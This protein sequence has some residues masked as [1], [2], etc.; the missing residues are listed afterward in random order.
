MTDGGRSLE[1]VEPVSCPVV[2]AVPPPGATAMPFCTGCGTPL[3]EGQQFCTSCGAPGQPPIPIVPVLMGGAGLDQPPAAGWE[4]VPPPADGGPPVAAAVAAGSAASMEACQAVSLA[5]QRWQFLQ[6][7]EAGSGGSSTVL[8]PT[9]AELPRPQP[10]PEPEP[11]RPPPLPPLLPAAPSP[12]V[13]AAVAA[14]VAPSVERAPAAGDILQVSGAECASDSSWSEASGAASRQRA[15]RHVF[16]VPS[17][18]PHC[19][20]ALS[21]TR[22][23]DRAAAATA[24]MRFGVLLGR[25]PA[26]SLRQ[27]GARQ[28]GGVALSAD[29]PI[30]LCAPRF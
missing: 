23:T 7:A 5:E 25:V 19:G 6:Q 13:A 16:K 18:R 14:G 22:R 4:M 15:V 28:G 11:E 2:A 12:P 10:E 30:S 1:A 3:S 26:P 20:G 8:S 27:V 29:A 17:S 24:L 21:L 9:P